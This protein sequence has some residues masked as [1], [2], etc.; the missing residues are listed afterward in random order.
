MQTLRQVVA[1]T[2]FSQDAEQ[3]LDVAFKLAR[4]ASVPLTLVHVCEL[5]VDGNDDQRLSQCEEL[6]TRVVA[7][8]QGRGVELS[9][10]LRCGRPWE[11]LNNVAAEVGAGLI[12]VGRHGAGRG[13]SVEIGSVAEQL[14]RT[15]S[16]PVLTVV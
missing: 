8:H 7:T 2:D 15:A 10:V 1:G 6:L 4:S 5:G 13:R 9:A 11:K 14:V 12:V 3:A 16:R